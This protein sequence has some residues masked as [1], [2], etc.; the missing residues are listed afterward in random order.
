MDN[1]DIP[2]ILY[3]ERVAQQFG[4][5]YFLYDVN[6]SS[7]KHINTAFSQLWDIDVASVINS[8]A[9]LLGTVNE[10]DTSYLISQ[11]QKLLE[12]LEQA[13]IEFR[14]IT[15]EKKLKWVC[16]SACV[17]REAEGLYIGGYA[18]D[19]TARRE[20]MDTLLKYN[21]K[22]NSTLEIISHDLAAPFSNIQGMINLIEEHVK[23]GDTQ[24]SQMI[25]FIRED[26]IRG[27]DMI[28]DFVNNEFLE[29]S[30][31]VLHKERMDIV[32]RILILMDNYKQR[33]GMIEKNFKMTSSSKTIFLS[34]DDLKFMQ[35]MNNLLSNAIKFTHNDGTIVVSVQE[36]E[37]TVLITVAD[38]GVG[39]PEQVQPFLFDKFTKARRLGIRGERSIGMGMSIIKI[40]VELHKGKIW[41]ESTEN[42][43]STFY[44]EL[45]KE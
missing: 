18:L 32:N 37:D 11:Y 40:I 29:S 2:N 15:P 12:G 13:E 20:Y 16:L 23:Q 43:G 21:S 39:I 44:I 17:F 4:Q 25:N 22:K 42:V 19:M 9:S 3:M 30:Q 6:S 35:V 33:E 31:V 34:F 45:P 7:F 36:Q 26:A 28:R 24:M 1:G 27:S 38:D 10:E 8:P 41:F 5:V 14:I